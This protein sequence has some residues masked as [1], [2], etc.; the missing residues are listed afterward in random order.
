MTCVLGERFCSH[1]S[2]IPPGVRAE[3]WS[4]HG[5]SPGIRVCRAPSRVGTLHTGNPQPPAWRRKLV[6]QSL[7]SRCWGSRVTC[8]FLLIPMLVQ[9][10][11][12]LTCWSP[13]PWFYHTWGWECGPLAV[14]GRGIWW[15]RCFRCRSSAILCHQL[16]LHSGM[17]RNAYPRFLSTMGADLMASPTQQSGFSRF[18]IARYLPQWKH[19]PAPTVSTDNSCHL[20][21]LLLF[22]LSQWTN[23][24]IYFSEVS[25]EKHKFVLLAVFSY[26]SFSFTEE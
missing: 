8:E 3:T 1:A 9:T 19:V 22:S 5:G 23:I 25:E 2:G 26:V 6:F 15:S 16:L 20:P 17:Q 12:C 18:C 13:R 7:G 11:L 4:A 14:A 10:R 21:L 24:F